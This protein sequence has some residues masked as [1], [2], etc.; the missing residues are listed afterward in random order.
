MTLP[1]NLE[2]YS[3]GMRL[4]RIERKLNVFGEIVCGGVGLGA[5]YAAYV[6]FNDWGLSHWIADLAGFAAFAFVG[7]AAWRGFQKG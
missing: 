7:S 1:P 4:A 2:D 5:G 6:V 3:E